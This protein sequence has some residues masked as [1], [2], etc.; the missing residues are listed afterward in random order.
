MENDRSTNRVKPSGHWNDCRCIRCLDF[1]VRECCGKRFTTWPAFSRH[2]KAKHN[3]D[4]SISHSTRV[5]SKRA[6]QI[7]I[8]PDGLGF[9]TTTLTT[10]ERLAS[11]SLQALTRYAAA[12]NDVRSFRQQ[13]FTKKDRE[14]LKQ[15]EAGTFAGSL[16]ALT[17]LVN[18]QAKVVYQLAQA[19][20]VSVRAVVSL[21]VSY[22]LELL[23]RELRTSS[24]APTPKNPQTVV[25]TKT[26]RASSTPR[27]EFLQEHGLRTPEREKEVIEYVSQARSEETP[28]STPTVQVPASNP[29]AARN[30]RTQEH[31]QDPTESPVSTSVPTKGTNPRRYIPRT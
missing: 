21:L 16:D 11:V 29:T 4:G 19:A 18:D 27:E 5:S 1:P 23:S 24:S 28:R 13:R 17:P 15:L 7:V 12:L 31:V 20:N 10:P 14:I 26:V 3:R 2:T 9:L 6:T 30:G 8:V 22:G 25:R